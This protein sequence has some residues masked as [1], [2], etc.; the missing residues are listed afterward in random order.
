MSYT[1]RDAIGNSMGWEAKLTSGQE[2]KGQSLSYV[3]S[4][5]RDAGFSFPSR[6][7]DQVA[8]LQECGFTVNRGRMKNSHR[9]GYGKEC[10]VVASVI[11]GRTYEKAPPRYISVASLTPRRMP[12]AGSNS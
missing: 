3:V 7:Y 9:A 1:I 8:L 6:Y 4:S 11:P 2:V 12:G 10:D 5:V